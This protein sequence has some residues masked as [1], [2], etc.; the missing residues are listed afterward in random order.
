MFSRFSSVQTLRN[1]VAAN[2]SFGA[3]ENYVR[4]L[5]QFEIFFGARVCAVI[6]R[7]LY[8]CLRLANRCR[9]AD[10]KRLIVISSSRSNHKLFQAFMLGVDQSTTRAKRPQQRHDASLRI[11]YPQ[12]YRHCFVRWL[13]LE[14]YLS[15]QVKWWFLHRN[16]YLRWARRI[17]KSS[18]IVRRQKKRIF[19]IE[20]LAVDL[21]PRVCC[22]HRG[23]RKLKDWQLLVCWCS[24]H[25]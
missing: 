12:R 9:F 4:Y 15:L 18:S 2:L 16:F 22:W 7:N 19:G 8:E 24:N 17:N 5:I 6:I 23:L 11:N 25:L 21:W 14:L 3:R 13:F 20:I 10:R 1:G